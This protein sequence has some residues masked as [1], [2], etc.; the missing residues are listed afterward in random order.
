MATFMDII[1]SSFIGAT[2]LIIML[3]T[4][5]IAMENSA[6]ANGEQQVQEALISTTQYLEGELRN[7]GFGVP[8]TQR[9]VT[10][11]DS[12]TVRYRVDLPPLG[13]IDTVAF[14]IGNTNELID[15]PNEQDR[16]LYRQVNGGQPFI[17]GVVTQFHLRYF[18]RAGALLSMPVLGTDLKKIYEIESTVEVQNSYA[19]YRKQ[20]QV[21]SG[22]RDALYSSVLWKQTRLAS[23]NLRR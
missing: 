4:N 6:L 13:V 20:D 16:F 21:L 10:L 5:D 12:S 11:A 22:E 15:T 1:L 23:Q 7:M 18:D 19:L 17:M 14:Y 8:D 3:T 9:V 2:L